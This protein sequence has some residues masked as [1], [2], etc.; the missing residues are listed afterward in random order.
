[1]RSV[2]IFIDMFVWTLDNVFDFNPLV[3]SEEAKTAV[4]C[5]FQPATL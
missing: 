2:Y 1:M 4:P 3:G 5:L